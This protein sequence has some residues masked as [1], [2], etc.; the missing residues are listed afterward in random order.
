MTKIGIYLRISDDDDGRSTATARQAEDCKRYAATKGWEVADTFEDIDVSAYQRTAKRPEFERM[1]EAVRTHE[2]AGVLAWKMDR[3]SRR[4]KDLV[5]LDEV[6]EA[7][8]G[9]IA[10]VTEGINT[11]EATGQFVSMM[12]VSMA[13]MESA[14]TSMRVKRAIAANAAAG[15]P[16]P[17]GR[18]AF[19]Y[20]V[21]RMTLVPAEAAL[22][23]EAADRILG[24]E[25]LRGITTVWKVRGVAAMG[26]T[27]LRRVLLSALISG[28]REYR[29]EFTDGTFPAII[30]PQE[31]A[32][33]RAILTDPARR[34]MA[35]NSRSYLLS[36]F[37]R[38][39]RCGER[40]VARP[41]A[42]KVRRYICAKAPES[43]NCGGIARIAEPIEEMVREAV[44]IALDGVDLKEYMDKPNGKHQEA[45][46]AAIRADEEALEE[47]SRDY[48]AERT[49]T[50][51]EFF[52]ARDAL[53][54]RLEANRAGLAKSN[55]HDLLA[56]I[57]GA[58]EELR[59]H[60]ETRGLDWQRAVISAVVDHVVVE[61]AVKGR[62]RF[63]PS[64]VQIVWRF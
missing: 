52:A 10:T 23:K 44:L 17:G 35:G 6:C 49:I 19:G 56:K 2:I 11:S 22:V 51:S 45:L 7:A 64:L 32:R 29:G 13:Q 62:N 24:G 8:G 57:A 39:G 37:L 25:S 63:D 15:K 1:L 33:L 50:R 48:Y 54:G 43:P 26:H 14:N 9:F 53:Q 30:T 18:K 36:G 31:S 28:Q 58:G 21:D 55:G 12:L 41:T 4:P 34:K 42:H 46:L 20:S 27:T 5:R 61:P 16:S 59:R 40:M 47:L 38:C 3:I 60:W